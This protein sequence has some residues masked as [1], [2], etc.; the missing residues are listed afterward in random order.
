MTDK[1]QRDGILSRKR[2]DQSLERLYIIKMKRLRRLRGLCGDPILVS[3]LQ[4]Q[5]A[6]WIESGSSTL[7]PY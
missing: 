4:N 5:G 1:K 3:N 2:D 7:I 6:T